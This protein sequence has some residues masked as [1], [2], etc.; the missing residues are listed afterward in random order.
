MAGDL[1]QKPRRG[2]RTQ[3][4]AGAATLSGVDW[5]VKEK[6]AP[7]GQLSATDLLDDLRAMLV[8]SK[9]PTDAVAVLGVTMRDLY[10]DEGDDFTQGLAGGTM[11]STSRWPS[12]LRLLPPTPVA[13]VPCRV[14]HIALIWRTFG[15]V[16]PELWPT[17][18]TLQCG[19]GVFSFFRYRAG[20]DGIPGSGR[21]SKAKAKA[22]LLARA[23]KTA[24]HELGHMFG[25][26]H[27]VHR[28]S[29]STSLPVHGL[30]HSRGFLSILE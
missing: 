22:Q 8:K 29:T 11:A 4:W 13:A 20:H 30:D 14:V 12:V 10:M 5:R 6:V 23:N 21:L 17:A 7:H 27:C 1:R 16:L 3:V 28:C 26:G 25:I 9:F 15:S 24:V 2:D 18:G 19:C